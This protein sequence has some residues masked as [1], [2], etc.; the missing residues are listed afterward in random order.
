MQYRP[1]PAVALALEACLRMEQ[2]AAAAPVVSGRRPALE[3]RV[4]AKAGR[5]G[6]Q[7]PTPMQR[8]QACRDALSKLDELGWNRSYHQRLF[9]DDFLVRGCCVMYALVTT[10]TD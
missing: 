3:A 6:D 7:R 4:Q 2:Q 9:H 1:N 5:G 10:Q 8:M